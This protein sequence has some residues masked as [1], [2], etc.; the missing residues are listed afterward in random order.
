MDY[1]QYRVQTGQD[2]NT[3]VTNPQLFNPILPHPELHLNDNSPLVN[4]GFDSKAAGLADYDS[5]P[6]KIGGRRDIGAYENQ[7][8]GYQYR[9]FGQ[10][11]NAKKF[12]AIAQITSNSQIPTSTQHQ[13]QSAETTELKPPFI[14]ERGSSF[15]ANVMR[16]TPVFSDEFNAGTVLTQ[17]WALANRT[18][19]NSD[20]CYYLP[21]IP[22]ISTHDSKSCLTIKA[23]KISNTRYESGHCKSNITFA[24]A[25]NEVYHLQASIKLLAK[26]GS[27]FKGFAQTYGAWPAFWTVNEASWPV[28]G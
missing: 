16:W 2:A 8:C 5:N 23:T 18:D 15:T 27:E 17:N 1:N 7:C 21:S 25:L 6:R 22:Q 24:P 3:I 9:L 11:P 12:L 14:A 26:Q 28:N 19:Y 10:A 13:Y 20:I 4:T